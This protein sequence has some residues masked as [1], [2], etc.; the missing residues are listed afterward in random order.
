MQITGVVVN[1]KKKFLSLKNFKISYK[2]HG[3]RQT[4]K[5]TGIL[6]NVSL[7]LEYCI[8]VGALIMSMKNKGK[9]KEGCRQMKT[10]AVS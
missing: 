7:L 5:K 3:V 1:M 9:R 10:L 6:H 2:T 4:I 8:G